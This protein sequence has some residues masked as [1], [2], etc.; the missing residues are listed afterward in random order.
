MNAVT[1]IQPTSEKQTKDKPGR[2]KG[3]KGK[4]AGIELELPTKY[5]EAAE[6]AAEVSPFSASEIRSMVRADALAVLEAH[7]RPVGE[8]V[9]EAMAKTA[10]AL[11][12]IG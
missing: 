10:A 11:E 9:K 2:K 6:R 4:A 7:M 5:S 8:I 1:D 12:K 3:E